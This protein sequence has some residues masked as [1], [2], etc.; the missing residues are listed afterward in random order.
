MIRKKKCGSLETFLSSCL[1]SSMHRAA[2]AFAAEGCQLSSSV[3]RRR[4]CLRAQIF[5]LKD[6]GP[7]LTPFLHANSSWIAGLTPVS[8]LKVLPE[9]Q[10]PEPPRVPRTVPLTMALQNATSVLSSFH[11]VCSQ[12]I[13]R[14]CLLILLVMESKAKC[15]VPPVYF[16]WTLLPQLSRADCLVLTARIAGKFVLRC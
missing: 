2:C 16:P 15:T 1:S 11:H 4:S 8:F 5:V 3:C 12:V 10:L 6:S 13:P 9:P 14:L 7:N